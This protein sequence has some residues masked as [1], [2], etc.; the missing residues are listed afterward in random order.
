MPYI[1][2]VEEHSRFGGLGALVAEVLAE[3][4]VPIKILGIPD[5]DV[6]HGTSR[7]IFAHYG[8]DADGIVKAAL[9]FLK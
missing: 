7:E 4:P 9:E 1:I 2:T 8:L 3:Y 5:E 6:I